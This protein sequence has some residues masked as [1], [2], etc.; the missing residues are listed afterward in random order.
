MRGK[1]NK[2]SESLTLFSFFLP[3]FGKE[4]IKPPPSTPRSTPAASRCAVKA[5]RGH[6]ALGRAATPEPV[7]KSCE[8]FFFFFFFSFLFFF[9]KLFYF[10]LFSGFVLFSFVLIAPTILF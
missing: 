4:R 1:K 10:I 3:G 6:R 8:L 7:S 5:A 2:L 9:F